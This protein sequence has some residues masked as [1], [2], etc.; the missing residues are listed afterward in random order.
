[1]TIEAYRFD[2]DA[3]CVVCDRAIPPQ[4]PPSASSS[5][6]SPPPRGGA[7]SAA[8]PRRRESNVSSSLRSSDG[9]A[10]ASSKPMRRGH[11]AA[12]SSTKPHAVTTPGASTLK[13]NKSM[14]KFPHHHHHHPAAVAR[15]HHHA[16]LSERKS[17]ATATKPRS[18]GEIIE[19]I[20]IDPDDD[21]PDPEYPAL[22]CSDECRLIDEARNELT[23]LRMGSL[24]THSTGS[25]SPTGSAAAHSSA[26][27]I[28]TRSDAPASHRRR[29]SSGGS[30]LATAPDSLGFS[31]LSP[32]PSA[33]P[34][35]TV[36]A[37]DPSIS[38]FPFPS[39]S[40]PT[41]P[42]LDFGAR[43]VS[44]GATGSYSY[45]P[46][47]MQR[48]S[49]S[50]GLS[51]AQG[52]LWL[53]PDK[54]FS[55]SQSASVETRATGR[56]GRSLATSGVVSG[57]SSSATRRSRP[58]A[59]SASADPPPVFG[60]A[61][62]PRRGPFPFSETPKAPP[63]ATP[64]A[65]PPPSRSR[66]SASLALL[67][68]SLTPGSWLTRADSVTSLSGLTAQGIMSG[69]PSLPVSTAAYSPSS[70]SSFD[71]VFTPGSVP[72]SDG[73]GLK[74]Q[75]SLKA[76]LP[77]VGQANRGLFYFSDQEG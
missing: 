70:V 29:R 39:Q 61:P 53:G 9:T 44:R 59:L 16:T 21:H 25:S 76:P 30:S 58:P 64:V 77:V 33:A 27:P 17:A 54:G 46:S 56:L 3:Y 35:A 11:S 19:V 57:R 32:I 31:T 12:T 36:G 52:G 40:P 2:I 24:G 4:A 23:L 42:A 65:M 22:Y 63:A 67:G 37:Y 13:R 28:P 69:G 51:A 75:L 18:V 5:N 50:D 43:R 10:T 47:L 60:S 72:S 14:T 55:R 71:S 41:A 73:S 26:A 1:M 45:R 7:S 66:S 49:S 68:S 74:G 20:E 34:S 62:A 15:R 38:A 8:G 6:N 48:V